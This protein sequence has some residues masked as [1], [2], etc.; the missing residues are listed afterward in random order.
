VQEKDLMDL[1]SKKQDAYQAID[2]EI[3]NQPPV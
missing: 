2:P 1:L 3:T